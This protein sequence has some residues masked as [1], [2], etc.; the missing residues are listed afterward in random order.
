MITSLHHGELGFE[1]TGKTVALNHAFEDVDV[2][3]LQ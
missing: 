1:S 2:L 3:L